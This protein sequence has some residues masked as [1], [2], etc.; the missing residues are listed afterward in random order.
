MIVY[1]SLLGQINWN[2]LVAAS[3]SELD[4]E[5]RRLYRQVYRPLYNVR[6]GKCLTSILS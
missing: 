2:Y 4:L 3:L 6:L 5:Q 1:N